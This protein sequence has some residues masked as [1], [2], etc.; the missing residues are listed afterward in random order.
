MLSGKV[1]RIGLSLCSIL[2]VFLLSLSSAWAA[3]ELH[4]WP[5]GW[6]AE[7]QQYI[8]ERVV[9]EFQEKHPGVDVVITPGS[10]DGGA[11]LIVAVAAGVAPDLI[12]TGGTTVVNYVPTGLLQPIDRFLEKWENF[13]LVYPGAWENARWEG[14]TYSVPFTVDLRLVAY[15]KDI[16]AEAGLDPEN[17]PQSW[18]ELE[19]AARLTTKTE[20]DKVVRRGIT[21]PTRQSSPGVSQRFGHFLIQAGGNL[22]S[23]DSR[24]PLFND[25]IGRET[26]EYM[27]RL[28]DIGHPPGF[29]APEST[30]ISAFSAQQL[31]MNPAASY[32]TPGN[33]LK[34]NP[35]IVDQLGAFP[36]RRSPESDPVALAFIN[37]LGIPAASEQPELAWDFMEQLLTHE[38]A[39]A[40]VELNGYMM[41]RMDLAEWIQE[42]RPGLVPW[43]SAM[44]HVHVWPQIPGGIDGYNTLGN[45]VARALLGEIAPGIA[46]DQAEK[47][48][49]T[50]FD[51]Y[52]AEIESQ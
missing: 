38:N 29:V 43:F 49:Q 37:G 16:F 25:D 36:P 3:A 14:K 8:K 26:L 39:R 23:E 2:V 47:D 13:D 52:W 42:N 1:S 6:S 33:L 32:S 22:I 40:F 7:M 27:K 12:M 21:L 28:Y 5:I 15:H 11:R 45:W 9:P 19:T 17:P 48:Q 50:L 18:E 31:A 34:Q 51:E 24:R 35:D 4:V 10:W 46:L 41:P 44:E 20:G 30:G